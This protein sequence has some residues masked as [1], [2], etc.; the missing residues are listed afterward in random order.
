MSRIIALLALFALLPG[1]LAF[2]GSSPSTQSHLVVNVDGGAAFYVADAIGGSMEAEVETDSSGNKTVRSISYQPLTLEIPMVAP[3]VL[4]WINQSFEKGWPREVQLFATDDLGNVAWS[5]TLHDALISELKLPSLDASAEGP[6]HVSVTLT[7][8]TIDYEGPGGFVQLPAPEHDLW[9]VNNFVGSIGDLAVE[10]SPIG[11][12]LP[13]FTAK[14]SREHV[15][16]EFGDVRL[17]IEARHYLAWTQWFE[18]FVV[19]GTSTDAAELDGSIEFLAPDLETVL[20]VVHLS[21]L[22]PRSIDGS[23][24]AEGFFTVD[25]Y[26]E[27]MRL[28]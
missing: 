2:A 20:G 9:Q 3:G 16:S 1:S 23:T 19:D 28:E 25:L 15:S 6:A 12:E 14:L 10:T 11:A 13:H 18:R 4:D 27:G 26:V 17:T 7:A 8:S 22:G 24:L 21:H 5:R